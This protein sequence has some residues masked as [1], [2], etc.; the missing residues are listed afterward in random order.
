MDGVDACLV[1][2]SLTGDQLDFET[3]VCLTE[4]FDTGLRASIETA[5][6]GSVDDAAALHYDLGSVYA[7]VAEKA[8]DGRNLDLVGLHGQTVAHRDGRYTMQVGSPAQLAQRLGVPVV[9]NF[10][11]GDIAAGGNG[12]PLMPYL[13]WL[14]CRNRGPALTLNIG[15]I[16]NLAAIPA[17]AARADVRGFD[18][19]PGMCLIDE[20]SRLLFDSQ[21]DLNARHSSS[22]TVNEHLLA[23]LMSHPFINRQPP[24][25]TGRDEFGS[26]M[27]AALV[28]RYPLPP[29]DFIRTLVRFTAGSIAE[30][31]R[32]FG[33][34]PLD[35]GEL[36]ISG[37]GLRHPLVSSDLEAE[38]PGLKVVTS[39]AV[40]VDPDFKEA[41]LMAV[42]AVANLEGQPGNMPAVTGAGAEV[43]LGQVT[44]GS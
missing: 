44:A 15:G 28:D 19:G 42:L 20:A 43:I 25:S 40:G 30:N 29:E 21:A 13:D 31:V 14:L 11:E 8:A 24:K 27:V 37:G 2:M 5:L 6:N 33:N 3:I 32:R 4:P 34:S 1:D 36:I 38:L 39:E 17:V 41:L 35:G 23:E 26:G 7:A 22:G 18:T 10:R 12:A 9:S 16:A